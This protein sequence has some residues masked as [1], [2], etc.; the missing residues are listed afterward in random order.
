MGR[1]GVPILALDRTNSSISSIVLP[2]VLQ[3]RRCQAGEEV[4]QERPR[5]SISQV[6]RTGKTGKSDSGGRV[7]LRHPLGAVGLARDRG[8][9]WD[10]PECRHGQQGPTIVIG[11]NT[12]SRA[13]RTSPLARR[14]AGRQAA[15]VPDADGM[16]GQPPPVPEDLSSESCRSAAALIAF[17]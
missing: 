3:G 10:P 14:E 13:P 6:L 11:I 9:L 17:K 1:I 12:A 16:G 4:K 8:D 7:D 2:Q 15:N 5:T